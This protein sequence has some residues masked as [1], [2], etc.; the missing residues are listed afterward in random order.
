MLRLEEAKAGYHSPI[1]CILE[2][3]DLDELNSQFFALS[4]VRGNP[5]KSKPSFVDGDI[6]Q[7]REN[8]YN[9]L[10]RLRTN[11]L[12]CCNLAWTCYRAT[13]GPPNPQGIH[14]HGPSAP[15]D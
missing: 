10:L 2:K 12:H 3:V 15:L 11:A 8:L 13:A 6:F 5:E 4:Y 1:V 9:V 14:I 7:I